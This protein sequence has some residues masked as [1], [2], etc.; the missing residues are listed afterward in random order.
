MVEPAN[1]KDKPD[2]AGS[3]GDPGVSQTDIDALLGAAEG[4]AAPL[5]EP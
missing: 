5:G 1:P 2:A 3:G 4:A